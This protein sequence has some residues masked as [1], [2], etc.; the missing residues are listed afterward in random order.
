MVGVLA[1]SLAP[2]APAGAADP[3]PYASSAASRY[4]VT[5][6]ARSCGGYQDIAANQV[7]D[8]SAGTLARPGRDSPYQPGQPVD[9][10]VEDNVDSGCTDLT[11]WRFTLGGGHDAKGVTGVS[12]TTPPTQESGSRLD[13]VGKDTGGLLGGAV[14]VALTDEEVRNAGRRQLWVQGEARAG[15]G[16]GVLRCSV[17]GRTGGNLQW[18]SFP[19][20]IRH[21]FCYAYYVKNPGDPGIVT[22]RMSL[23]KPVGYPQKLP[24]RSDLSL[25]PE[26]RFALTG[27][28]ATA[29]FTR[30]AGSYTVLA[31]PPTGW[32]VADL[33]CV[34]SD[35]ATVDVP[36]G[37]VTI[38]LAARD[39]VTCTYS[40]EPPPAGTGLTLRVFTGGVPAAFGLAVDGAG[41]RQSAAAVT[42]AEPNAVT[43][44]GTDLSGLSAGPY[45]V[46][47]TPPA[48]EAATWALTGAACNG[49]PVRVTGM[50]VRLDLVA[51]IAADCVVQLARRT[52][53][54]RLRA[55]TAG[56]VAGAGFAIVPADTAAAGW[57]AA[58]NTTG[59]GVAASAAGDLPTDLPPGDY[60]VTAIPP[61]SGLDGGWKLSALTCDPA[62]KGATAGGAV[63][64]TLA[65][66]GRDPVCTASYQVETPTRMRVTVR[67]TGATASRSAPA[68]VE[69]SC[70]DGSAGRVV[71]AT[72]SPG[73]QASLPEPLAFLGPTECTIAQPAAGGAARTSVTVERNGPD[74]SLSLPSEIRIARDVTQYT[75]VVT[76]EFAPAAG[77]QG[78]TSLL[79]EIKALPTV[80]VGLGM[81][82]FGALVFLGVLLRRRVM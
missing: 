55:V 1:G 18:L 43:A 28:A 19:S 73:Q 53:T 51:G 47:V 60:L 52:P 81:V 38:A 25:A 79:D 32:R 20:G 44:T 72:D 36:A 66:G 59:Y 76:D 70:V 7:R 22:I 80:L 42:T 14:T 2:I 69:L 50:A 65:P 8:D 58:A 78:G 74:G 15:Y 4:Q 63:R 33:S 24:F 21:V 6:A 48:A 41:G 46:T 67:A 31:Q 62:G 49:R 35:K 17:D 29:S 37:K 34:G 39:T 3:K 57:W 71:L 56:G 68:V 40:I 23:T 12:S 54:P 13:S 64:I 61:R 75:V 45:T 27:D 26:G 10:D 9:P 82:G 77:S 16:F 11:G 5:F 30:V